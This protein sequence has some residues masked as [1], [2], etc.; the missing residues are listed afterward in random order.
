MSRSTSLFSVPSLRAAEP[1]SQSASAPHFQ[2]PAVSAMRPSKRPR[3][4]ASLNTASAATWENLTAATDAPA[5]ALTTIEVWAAVGFAAGVGAVLLAF[6][7]RA[8]WGRGGS[9]LERG[10]E[11]APPAQG[12]LPSPLAGKD[13][14]LAGR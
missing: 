4:S 12:E 3:I 2:R 7:A 13:A 5:V 9:T 10:L 1:N 11:P 8:R 14:R 6:V